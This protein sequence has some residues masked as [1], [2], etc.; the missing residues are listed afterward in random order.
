MRTEMWNNDIVTSD[1][2]SDSQM[3]SLIV[4]VSDSVDVQQATK[5][6]RLQVD[7]VVRPFDV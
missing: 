7:I 5:A 6:I 4:G 2:V 3:P 1:Q